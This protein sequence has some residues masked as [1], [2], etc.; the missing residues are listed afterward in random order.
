GED[1]RLD[2]S[3]VEAEPGQVRGQRSL[4]AGK[5]CVHRREPP[6]V[7]DEIPVE[8][9][10]TEPVDAGDDVAWGHI[11][12]DPIGRHRSYAAVGVRYAS[13]ARDAATSASCSTA[14]YE[15]PPALCAADAA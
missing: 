11:D 9:G 2:I 8:G 12:G 13:C 7:F 6:A 10:I 14:T 3:E 1:H 4:E 15:A 5:S